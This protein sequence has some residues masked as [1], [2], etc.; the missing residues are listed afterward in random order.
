LRNIVKVSLAGVLIAGALVSTKPA[1]AAPSALGA[2]PSTDVYGDGVFHFDV[3]TLSRNLTKNFG[4]SVGLQ[5]G[6][7]D[8]AEIGFDYN[9]SNLGDSF[10]ENISFNAKYKLVDG[11]EKGVTVAAG[12]YGLGKKQINGSAGYANIGYVVA[13]KNFDFGRIHLGV[14]HA[15]GDVEE[16]DTSLTVSYDKYLTPK[17]QFAVDYYSGKA[18]YAGVQPS[19]YYSINEKAGFGLGYLIFNNDAP[20]QVYACFDYNFDFKKSA[21]AQ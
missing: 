6:I 16:D 12:G 9:T 13:S 19:I 11:G 3:D 8:K 10:G 21:P 17:V 4:T 20:N 15:F 14:A 7:G 2:Y 18:P 5:Y 1:S